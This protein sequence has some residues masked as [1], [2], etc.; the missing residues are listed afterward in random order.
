M[1]S[2]GRHYRSPI[3]AN[4]AEDFILPQDQQALP[5]QPYLSSGRP[6]KQNPISSLD[7]KALALPAGQTNSPPRRDY[8]TMP[9]TL[10]GAFRYL[11][12]AH[13]GFPAFETAH[14]NPVVQ[15]PEC[16]QFSF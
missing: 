2:P 1:P 10:P 3:S 5:F 8:F 4:H 6:A 15:G 13:S 9:R 12:A 16:H 14:Q 7:V 11:D